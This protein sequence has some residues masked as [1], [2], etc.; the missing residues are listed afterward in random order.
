[1]TEMQTEDIAC[2]KLMKKN[3]IEEGLHQISSFLVLLKGQKVSDTIIHKCILYK[4][5]IRYINYLMPLGLHL[6]LFSFSHTNFL[7]YI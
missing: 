4:V 6:I 3:M 7:T 5:Q 1:M 2:E